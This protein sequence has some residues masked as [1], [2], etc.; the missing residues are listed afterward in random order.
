VKPNVEK[1]QIHYRM[2]VGNDVV[3][4]KY[5]GVDSLPTSFIIDKEGRIAATHVGLVSR[6]DYQKDI[7]ELLGLNKKSGL[8]APVFASLLRAD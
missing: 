4:Q 8:R 6:R 5:G 3:A 7:D 2:V 1:H